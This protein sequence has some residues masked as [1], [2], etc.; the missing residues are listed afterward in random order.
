M[1][2]P[3][4]KW[5][6][7]LLLLP[8][9]AMG[10][11]HTTIYGYITDAQS[12][13]RLIGA[14]VYDTIS[15]KGVTS[16]TSGFYS[17]SIPANATVS[18]QANYVGY[19]PSSIHQIA[20]T[21]D[22]LVNLA[23]ETRNQLDEVVVVGTPS[24]SSP[25]S[26]QMSAIE[27]PVS[28]LK[29]IVML[30]GEADVLKA[31]QLLPGVQGGTEGSTGMYIRGGGPDENLILLD[32]VPLYSVSHVMGFFS[33][34][35][36]DAIKNVTLY[37]GNFPAQY[38]GRLSGIVDVRQKDG[39]SDAYHGSLSVGLLA[40]HAN[41]QGYIPYK[42]DNVGTTTFNIS[43]RRTYFDALMTPIMAA[44]AK[45]SDDKQLFGAY[46]YDINAK[47][48][49]SFP[50]QRDRLSASFYMGKDA[51]YYSLK[52]VDTVRSSQSEYH[53][54]KMAMRM[55]WGNILG[56][57]NWE[58]CYSPV[59]FSNT[60]LSFCNYRYKLK[61]S[62]AQQR[63]KDN[64]PYRYEQ[65]I[66]YNSSMSDLLLQSHYEWTP[67]PK[68]SLRFGGQY[69]Y[70]IFAPQVSNSSV[71]Q[72]EGN[73]TPLQFD[74]TISDGILHAHEASL[75]IEDS[76][77]P[78]SWL[79]ANIGVRM[80]L[81]AINGKVYPSIE[82]R[83]GMRA[84][85]TPDLAFKVSYSYTTQYVHMLSN[86]SVAL[87]TDLWVPSTNT[88]APM[89]AMIAAVGVSYNI[90]NQVELSI[91]GYYK[92][93]TNLLEYRD[94]TNF[95]DNASWQD[96][97]AM[98]DGWSYGIELL[99]QR[100]IGPVTGWIG[101]T[102]SRSMRQFDKEGQEVNFG[103]PFHAKYER[104][105]DLSVTLQYQISPRIDIAATFVYGTGTRGTLPLYNYYDPSHGLIIP[106]QQERNN[107]KM[108]DYH[109]LDIGANFHFPAKRAVRLK[110]AE[111]VLSISLYNAYCHDN[112]IMIVP[113][114]TKYNQ[115][116]FFPILPGISYTFNF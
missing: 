45:K 9:L 54:D 32:G 22:T 38:G 68:N 70:H 23:L 49:H 11:E 108:P 74:S 111:H 66:G 85:I 48:T 41:I 102:W 14:S 42:K 69:S 16:N 82:P 33:V 27:V 55:D 81:Y 53:S 29:G 36:A 113:R 34:F 115:I 26:A 63:E 78:W 87:P 10:V 46:F 6:L 90:L 60:Q 4:I 94:G 51:I 99:L 93:F 97:V 35:N 98:G 91:E 12:G 79:K 76:Y 25:A 101:Y 20:P 2:Y 92:R 75:Y 30:G 43:A 88:I 105:H 8:S 7:L 72:E 114:G 89:H 86:T 59:L 96:K 56:A 109:R 80:G 110:D 103:R 58:H 37:K 52:S 50:N 100:K 19:A 13:E 112:P 18:L 57:L 39:S 5:S 61:E 3:K 116:S 31:L 77:S 40:A 15:H 21:H 84:L 104:E 24:V 106:L 107:F 95:Y 67:I 17:L 83:V 44:M 1:L 73:S 47:L 28:Q 64:V 71:L 65:A 62:I